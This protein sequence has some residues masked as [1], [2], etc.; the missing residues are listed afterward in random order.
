MAKQ[1]RNRRAPPDHRHPRDPL[2]TSGTVP[3]YI[4]ILPRTSKLP[5]AASP[6]HR[7]SPIL[8]I[9][10]CIIQYALPSRLRRHVSPVAY[11]CAGRLRSGPTCM[12]RV[13]C[14]APAPTTAHTTAESYSL[15]QTHT[16]LQ[17]HLQ[18]HHA[19]QQGTPATLSRQPLLQ[20]LLHAVWSQERYVMN[21]GFEPPTHGVQ[22][23][24]SHPTGVPLESHCKVPRSNWK[25]SNVR[26]G[27]NG[28]PVL[29]SALPA[30]EPCAAYSPLA[31]SSRVYARS[32]ISMSALEWLSV[33][34]DP[35]PAGL[36][37]LGALRPV[38]LSSSS[39]SS[40]PSVSSSSVS[41]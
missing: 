11:S 3:V 35:R 36:R 40:P 17:M 19:I 37:A 25:T 28:V 20:P 2:R 38:R 12:H 33:F 4:V 15:Q 9:T 8:L 21:G 29:R 34:S 18:K 7:T 13:V 24:L 5:T 39:M 41:V 23:L 6:T 10:T 32:S 26:N 22:L 31:R 27:R 1:H 30:C 14:H 16:T